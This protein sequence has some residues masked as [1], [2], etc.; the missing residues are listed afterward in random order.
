MNAL[1]LNWI[2]LG[3]AIIIFRLEHPPHLEERWRDPMQCLFHKKLLKAWRELNRIW[4]LL[5]GVEIWCLWIKRNLKF[6]LRSW[7]NLI[8]DWVTWFADGTVDYGRLEWMKPVQL[9]HRIILMKIDIERKFDKRWCPHFT[10]CARDN[11]RVYWN[12]CRLPNLISLFD[13]LCLCGLLVSQL[14]SFLFVPF[15]HLFQK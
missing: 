3:A 1:E 8:Q 2:R 12:C 14:F 11:W 13:Q 5:G 7:S 15:P 9:I 6:D 4:T 10:L